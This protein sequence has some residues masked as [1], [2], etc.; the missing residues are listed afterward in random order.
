M[1]GGKRG[2]GGKGVEAQ[3]EWGTVC[4]YFYFFLCAFVCGLST[5]EPVQLYLE[6]VVRAKGLKLFVR[7]VSSLSPRSN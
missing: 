7:S 4:G 5:P 3:S 2:T 1:M 6:S